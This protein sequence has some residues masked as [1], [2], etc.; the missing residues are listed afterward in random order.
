MKLNWNKKRLRLVHIYDVS[1]LMKCVG[2]GQLID[3][4]FSFY[5]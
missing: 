5:Y 4:E 3:E 2:K 1:H